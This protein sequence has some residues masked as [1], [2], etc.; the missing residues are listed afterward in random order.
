M[1]RSSAAIR[2]GLTVAARGASRSIAA[3]VGREGEVWRT[4]VRVLDG[5]GR[6]LA[7]REP[8]ESTATD[9]EAIA[10]AVV[11]AVA[12]RERRR[13]IAVLQQIRR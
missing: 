12:Y 5:E 3:R 8:L 9:C 4:E 7:T 2:S 1:A 11:L 10:D 6:P 13:L